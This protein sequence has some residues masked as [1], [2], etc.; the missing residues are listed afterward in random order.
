MTELGVTVTVMLGEGVAVGP[1]ECGGAEPPPQPQKPITGAITSAVA[2]EGSLTFV[3]DLDRPSIDEFC[4]FHL[5]PMIDGT[6]TIRCIPTSAIRGLT[7]VRRHWR[8]VALGRNGRA[9][10]CSCFPSDHAGH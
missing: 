1:E 10:V 2:I 9:M 8:E 5:K 4:M 3:N 7:R 6:R